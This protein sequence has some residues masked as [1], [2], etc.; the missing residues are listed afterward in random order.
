MQNNRNF[1]RGQSQRGGR[2]SSRPKRLPFTQDM[3]QFIKTAVPQ[4]QTE[5]VITNAFADFNL[6]PELKALLEKNG[7][8]T[9]TPVQDQA[10]PEILNGR[11]I[12]ALANT[13][14]GKTLGFLLPLASF[15]IEAMKANKPF[16][17]LIIAPTRELA[18][19]IEE[20]LMKITTREMR[21][22][23]TCIIGGSSMGRQIQRLRM[24]NQ[25]LIGTPGRLV[26]LCNRGVIRLNEC[27]HVVLD[28]VD[29]MIDMGFVEDIKWMID[30][31]PESRQSLFFSATLDKKLEP[32]AHSFLK[33][34]AM[35]S[36][37]TGDASSQVNQDVIKFSSRED[38]MTQ[39][40][41]AMK[42]EDVKKVLIFANTKH[43]TD[44]IAEKLYDFG[45][46]AAA[47]HGDKNLNQRKRAL[48]AFKNDE[49]AVLVATDVAARGLDIPLVSHVINYDIP[50]S[51]E[52]YI[53]RIGRTGRAG[54]VGTALTMFEKRGDSAPRYD[55]PQSSSRSY[56]RGR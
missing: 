8:I 39:L 28:E 16:Q 51:H 35:V 17:A 43:E 46:D 47:I 25:F 29:R 5:Q 45:F 19:Q 52:E 36:V 23:S 40:V 38:K 7:F 30:Q 10:I 48:A 44:R 41:E 32:I 22:F 14:T 15:A 26:D 54:N 56:G 31:L 24:R 53:H 6:V 12:I 49:I 2:G 20:E 34:P 37:K 27:T 55:R 3:N 13:G 33:T 18:L 21:I 9:P 4:A 1:S 42:K 11:D 50:H